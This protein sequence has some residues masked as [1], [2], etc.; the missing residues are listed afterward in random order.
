M[1]RHPLTRVALCGL[2]LAALGTSCRKETP[3]EDGAAPASASAPLPVD[4]LAPNELGPG[5]EELFG[6]PLP[7]G[8][9][10]QGRF[11]D[12][13]IASG[14]VRADSVVAYVREHVAVERVEVG[15]ARTVFPAV[16]IHAGRQDRV[17][18]VEVSSDGPATRL[19]I[20]DVTPPPPAP[21]APA[22]VSAEELWRRA[23]FSRDGKPLNPKSLE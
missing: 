20:R 7:R 17:Y 16:R 3:T 6:L 4:R 21:A 14:N 11:R 1:R 15:A 19:L 8:M 22:P 12:F 10:V 9:T 13:A 18:R 23:G 5:N 2:W